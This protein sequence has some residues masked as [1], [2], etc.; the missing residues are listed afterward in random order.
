[1]F[2]PGEGQNSSHIHVSLEELVFWVKICA[3]FMY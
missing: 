3:I 1:M 2:V